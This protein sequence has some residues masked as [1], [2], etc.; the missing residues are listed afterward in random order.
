MR[1]VFFLF[2]SREVSRRQM[3][4]VFLLSLY[5]EEKE[6]ISPLKTKDSR[7]DYAKRRRQAAKNGR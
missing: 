5:K 1:G 3:D 7:A 6:D 4:G 2:F